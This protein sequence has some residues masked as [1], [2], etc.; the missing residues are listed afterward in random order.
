MS[1]RNKRKG[2]RG[3]LTPRRR[4]EISFAPRASEPAQFFGFDTPSKSGIEAF[5]NDEKSVCMAS[6]LV[7]SDLQEAAQKG[8]TAQAGDWVVSRGG[9]ESAEGV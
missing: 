9:C 6:E 4:R 1:K 5:V 8:V 3:P 2:E 7:E